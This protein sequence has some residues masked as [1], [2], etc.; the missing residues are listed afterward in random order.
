MVKLQSVENKAFTSSGKL[1]YFSNNVA[2]SQ[3]DRIVVDYYVLIDSPRIMRL[4]TIVERYYGTNDL[5]DVICQYNHL[6]TPFEV[7]EGMVIALPNITS[8]EDNL[9]VQNVRYVAILSKAKAY[10]T[11]LNLVPSSPA[12]IR[13]KVLYDTIG[14]SLAANTNKT[15]TKLSNGVMVF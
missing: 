2:M 7:N 6:L 12:Q 8:L 13:A 14:S 9:F 5:L 11:V 1:D 10:Q 15:Y 3:R 4:D